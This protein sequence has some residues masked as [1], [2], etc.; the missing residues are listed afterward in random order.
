MHVECNHCDNDWE[1][2]GDKSHPSM[3]T[4]PDCYYKVRLPEE[5]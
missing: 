4:C 3:V 2:G 5:A 1:Y